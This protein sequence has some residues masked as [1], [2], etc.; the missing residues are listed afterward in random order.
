[1]ALTEKQIEAERVK[2]NNWSSGNPNAF[3]F[4]AW[5][6]CREN[7]EI[8]L[9]RPQFEDNDYGVGWNGCILKTIKLLESQGFKVVTK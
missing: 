1:M 3:A 2:F 5:L 8:E 9:P 6:A 4:N 7:I